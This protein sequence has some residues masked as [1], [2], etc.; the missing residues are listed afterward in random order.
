MPPHTS[1]ALIVPY[2]SS[3]GETLASIGRRSAVIAMVAGDL[4]PVTT[5]PDHALR[6]LRAFWPSVASIFRR[7]QAAADLWCFRC[8]SSY[9][10]A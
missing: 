5:F 6:K 4:A 8:V 10:T 3:L 2:P 9:R 7:V 1:V